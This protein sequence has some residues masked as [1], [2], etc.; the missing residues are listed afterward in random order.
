MSESNRELNGPQGAQTSTAGP[1]PF[2]PG[3]AAVRETEDTPGMDAETARKLRRSHLAMSFDRVA[4]TY[5][6][7]NVGYPEA[8]IDAIIDLSGIPAGGRILEVGSGT[9]AA[10]MPFAAKGYRIVCV[11]PGPNMVR[12][13]RETFAGNSNVRVDGSTFEAWPLERQAFDLVF[14]AHSLYWVKPNVRFVKTADALRS[15]GS[16]AYFKNVEIPGEAPVDM[17]I[18]RVVERYMPYPQVRRKEEVERQFE[19]TDHFDPPAKLMIP[20]SCEREAHLYVVSQSIRLD[21]Y[22]IEEPKRSEFF[23]EMEKAIHAHGGRINVQYEAHLMIS[24]RRRGA[25]LW[26]RLAALARRLTSGR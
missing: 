14:S 23:A 21:Y 20:W 1:L 18:R 4:P 11:E 7:A 8:L 3:R 12:V 24:R 13:A 10:T 15:G 26:R 25:A 6:T 16:L 2:S 5:K 17:A 9:G 19:A 22:D